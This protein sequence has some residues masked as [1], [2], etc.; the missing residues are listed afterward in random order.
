MNVQEKLIIN[1]FFSIKK[2]EWN[3]KNFNILT[4]GMASGKSLCLKLIHFIEQVFA[5]NIFFTSISKDTFTAE[6]FYSNMAEQF[7]K[8]FH[9][10]NM[11]Y[12]YIH[13]E[14]SYF[15][16]CTDNNDS[17]IFDMTASWNK[18]TQKLEWNS[19]YINSKI[20]N[21]QSF[22]GDNNT[23][24]AAQHVRVQIYES[25]S[26]DFSNTLPLGALFIPASRAIASITNNFEIP[27]LYLSAFIRETKPFV[28]SLENISNN[29]VNN[30]LYF[31]KISI[32]DGSKDKTL[33]LELLNGKKITTLELSSG[34]QEL[35][36]LLLF[37][38]NLP[39]IKFMFGK[40][41]SIFIEEPSAHL[42]P[43]EQKN[44]IEYIVKIFHL[45]KKQKIESE[46]FFI[47]THSPYILNTINNMLKKGSMIK[48]FPDNQDR[49]NREVDI[50]HILSSEISAH[51]IEKDGT[52]LDMLEN[53]YLNADKIAEISF[54][55]NN[56]T[57]KLSEL[58]NELLYAKEGL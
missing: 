7:D 40:S 6:I 55:I 49:I 53:D 31:K 5:R 46:R 4:G 20:Q 54:A 42:F 47:T 56:D 8:I 35:L 36:Y 38:K 14:I 9:S 37:I 34:Q 39:N 33:E 29:D 43:L 57:N 3:I 50:P 16:K 13:T 27:D 21:W 22:F 51:F 44:S 12:D 2:F 15:Y 11:D 17:M 10:Q 25:I 24:D 19:D 48:R 28:L 32:K 26:H 58:N 52:V 30:L 41:V 18:K 23:A 45:L 1:N